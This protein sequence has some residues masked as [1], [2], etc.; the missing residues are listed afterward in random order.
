MNVIMIKG[1][2][3]IDVPCSFVEYTLFFPGIKLSIRAS[4]CLARALPSA[5]C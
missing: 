5:G 3:D 1:T 2:G 4:G